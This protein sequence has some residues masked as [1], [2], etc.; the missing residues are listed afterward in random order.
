MEN[1]SISVYAI[2]IAAYTALSLILSS[3][4]F[5]LVQVR[6]A[7]LLLVLCLADKKFIIPVTLG[8]FMTNLIGV[9]SGTNYMVLDII[10]GTLATFL[11]GVC[12]YAFKDVKL[13][14]KPVLSLLMPVIINAVMVGIELNIYLGIKLILAIAYVGFGELISV[15]ILGLILYQPI[16]KAIKKYIE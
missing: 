8:C 9:L 6:V 3:F 12:V 1:K 15:T 14:N 7:E 5:G 13:F 16:I 11:S 2:I 10:I 4:S